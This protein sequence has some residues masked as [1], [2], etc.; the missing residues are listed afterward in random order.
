[1]VNCDGNLKSG[2]EGW[3]DEENEV[4]LKFTCCRCD[5]IYSTGPRPQIHHRVSLCCTVVRVKC[6]CS[7]QFCDRI[8][9]MDSWFSPRAKI[10][11]QACLLSERHNHK[12]W[13]VAIAKR[14]SLLWSPAEWPTRSDY[15]SETCCTFWIALR[16]AMPPH[17]FL[18]LGIN[19]LFW[20]C[21]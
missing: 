9:L 10:G 20:A 2:R 1:M 5:W 17:L 16:L 18:T 21:L 13:C 4:V 7:A 12:C 8:G 3:V 14:R 6:G 11:L 15:A 19:A